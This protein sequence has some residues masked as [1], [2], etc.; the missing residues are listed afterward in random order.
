MPQVSAMVHPSGPAWQVTGRPTALQPMLQPVPAR[1]RFTRA[2]AH[3]SRALSRRSEAQCS[4]HTAGTTVVLGEWWESGR[5]RSLLWLQGVRT[6]DAN[7]SF[8][9][10]GDVRSK[11]PTSSTPLFLCSLLLKRSTKA[12]RLHRSST[13]LLASMHAQ[14]DCMP[15]MPPW[16]CNIHD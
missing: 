4:T 5:G 10:A 16:P 3:V 2:T 8:S 6:G 13:S 15:R 14:L 9:W 11:P 1:Q 7:E 12:P